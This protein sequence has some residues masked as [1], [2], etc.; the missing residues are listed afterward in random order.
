M[1]YFTPARCCQ[2]NSTEA[3]A[4]FVASRD[5]AQDARYRMRRVGVEL[6]TY[7]LISKRK[8]FNGY[9]CGCYAEIRTGSVS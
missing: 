7:G 1:A 8:Q 2:D 4:A 5:A 6:P 9:C 3:A